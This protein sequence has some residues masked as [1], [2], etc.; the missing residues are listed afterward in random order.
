MDTVYKFCGAHG[1]TI[2]RNLELKITPPNQFNDPFEFTPKI[3][4]SDRVSYA[5][6]A[7][8]REDV[9]KWLYQLYLKSN[10]RGSFDEYQKKSIDILIQA[11]EH[12]SPLVEKEFLCEVGK[13]YG[14][15]CLSKNRDSI[16]MWGHYCDKLLGI[17]IGFDKASAIFKQGK[18]LRPVNY[19]GERVILDACWEV[20]SPEL[21]NYE[22]QIIHSKSLAWK[23]E[24]E[25]RQF[26]PLSSSSLVK[27]PLEDKEKHPDNLLRKCTQLFLKYLGF[28]NT[29][30]SFGYFLPIPPEAIVSVTLGPR[31]SPDFENEVRGILQK[32]CFSHVEIF[33]RAVLHKNNFLIDFESV[34]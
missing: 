30:Q 14:I 4:Y 23:Y 7:L 28:K 5:K 1:L 17:V 11:P 32:P 33:D 8:D 34:Q 15:L 21:L 31:C 10:F 24:G 16:L 18:G 29:A 19:V 6:R 9:H 27:K 22:E 25:F 2:L 20:G 13:R 26:F 12:T 3:I